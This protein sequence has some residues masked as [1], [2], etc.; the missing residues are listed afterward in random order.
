[1]SLLTG[2][3]SLFGVTAAAGDTHLEF[4]RFAQEF[5]RKKKGKSLNYFSL[6]YTRY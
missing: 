2:E 3:E 6:S 5:K 1:V 4:G